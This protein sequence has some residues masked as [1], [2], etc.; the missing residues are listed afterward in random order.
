MSING[1]YIQV[2]IHTWWG[3]LYIGNVLRLCKQNSQVSSSI[4]VLTDIETVLSY[5]S[6]FFFLCYRSTQLPFPFCVGTHSTPDLNGFDFMALALLLDSMMAV[7]TANIR[8]LHR[9]PLSISAT[10]SQI[11][12]KNIDFA[13]YFFSVSIVC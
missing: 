1:N 3:R 4:S 6:Q 11:Y 7:A 10:F 2:C 13:A 8:Y 5:Q 12:A 9:A